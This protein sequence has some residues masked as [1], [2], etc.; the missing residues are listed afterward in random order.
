MLDMP[1]DLCKQIVRRGYF[2]ATRKREEGQ[3]RPELVADRVN[4]GQV[5]SALQSASGAPQSSYNPVALS[6]GVNPVA[7]SDP[8]GGQDAGQQRQVVVPQN[9]PWRAK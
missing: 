9:S 6:A 4:V 2:D 7:L 5:G 3:A 1:Q 8:G